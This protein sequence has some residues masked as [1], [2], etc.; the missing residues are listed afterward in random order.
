MILFS[1][2]KTQQR[3][4]SRSLRRLF[5]RF[6]VECQWSLTIM[7]YVQRVSASPTRTNSFWSQALVLLT[8]APLCRETPSS[9]DSAMSFIISSLPALF[10]WIWFVAQV[11]AKIGS[12]FADGFIRFL[13]CDQSPHF[14]LSP[15]PSFPCFTHISL[16]LSLFLFSSLC[17]S[18]IPIRTH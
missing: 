10:Y 15:V 1:A 7:M 11:K 18:H 13:P 14:S 4:L 9:R 16:S 5:V 12:R 2:V 3:Q 17:L 8:V 6:A